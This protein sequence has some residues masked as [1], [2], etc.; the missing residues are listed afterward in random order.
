MPI[1][2]HR[3]VHICKSNVTTSSTSL[4]IEMIRYF[5]RLRLSNGREGCVVV[6]VVVV[7]AA[8]ASVRFRLVGVVHGL[9][10]STC[11]SSCSYF[12]HHILVIT[13]KPC[14]PLIIT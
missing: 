13:V 6:V 2:S 10:T 7:A 4:Y 1:F 8:A 12:P 5:L 3:N 14:A 9:S 11:I